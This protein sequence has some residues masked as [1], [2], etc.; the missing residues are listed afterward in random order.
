MH[1]VIRAGL[2]ECERENIGKRVSRFESVLCSL[3]SMKDCRFG[4]FRPIKSIRINGTRLFVNLKREVEET[5][6]II[7]LMPEKSKEIRIRTYFFSGV[8]QQQY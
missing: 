8:L 5:N 7:A 4:T 2:N 3:G 1:D 6:T